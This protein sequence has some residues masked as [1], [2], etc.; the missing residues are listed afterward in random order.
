MASVIRNSEENKSMS[1]AELPD[2]A[3]RADESGSRDKPAK[4]EQK[5]RTV[6][7]AKPSTSSGRAKF[8]TIYKS[9]QGYWTRMGTLIGVGVLGLL[10][11]YTIYNRIPGYYTSNIALGR[12]VAIGASVGFLLIFAVVALY[13]MNKPGN[14]DF[15]IQTD[16][17]MKKVNWTS[18]RE[19]IGSTK[20][21]IIFMFL[22]AIFLFAM[23]QAF[24][25]FMFGIHVLKVPPVGGGG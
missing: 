8:F 24:G 3:D 25:W 6:E 2:E 16:S 10:L 13:V 5:P 23:D 18:R 22:V 19:L 21:V 15:L 4:R 11:A 9:G 17:E 20:I 1:E 14:V 7:Y 12:R